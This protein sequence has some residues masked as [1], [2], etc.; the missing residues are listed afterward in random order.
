[1][2]VIK[3]KNAQR[4]RRVIDQVEQSR[5]RPFLERETTHAV[6]VSKLKFS[7]PVVVKAQVIKAVMHL[8]TRIL[9]I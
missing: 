7:N 2:H 4:L 5:D 1:M 9:S 6:A 3:K 8:L